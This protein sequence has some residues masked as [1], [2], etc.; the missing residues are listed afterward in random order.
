[1][2]NEE[3]AK[4]G[5]CDWAAVMARHA[6]YEAQAAA[7]VTVNKVAIFD[8]LS[9]AGVTVVTVGFDGYGDS[10]QIES[11]DTIR[12]DETVDL[13]AIDI[14][15][16]SA[17]YDGSG[18]DSVAMPVGDAVEALAYDLLRATHAGWENNDGAYGEFRLDVA[19]RT[20]TLD[21]NDRYTAVESYSHEW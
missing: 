18:V 5:E 12:G 4:S 16:Q 2:S 11:V 1:M 14:L 10:G 9:T 8:A 19:A 17:R 6:A 20:I 13:P 15:L 21:H 7:L 3:T